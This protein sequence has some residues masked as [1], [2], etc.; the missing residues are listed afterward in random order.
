MIHINATIY[1]KIL[2]GII[3]AGIISVGGQKFISS[4]KNVEAAT[5][6][7]VTIF[8]QQY[9][10]S[11]LGTTH[12]GPRGTTFVSI[13]GSAFFQCGA[14]M[15]AVYQG[16]HGTDVTRLI[17]YIYTSPTVTTTPTTTPT[18][19][20]TPVVSPTLTPSPIPSVSPAPSVT[21]SPRHED[22]ENN[23]LEEREDVHI[24]FEHKENHGQEVR[25][26]A[27]NKINVSS[28]KSDKDND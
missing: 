21:P 5:P 6:C 15:T 8:G 13:G 17:P 27:R 1:K 11:S 20:P 4:A 14:D 3:T 18:E 22:D 23:E 9:D 2:V 12:S 19:T 16:M 7:V 10:V 25:E 28:H 24:V 26:V